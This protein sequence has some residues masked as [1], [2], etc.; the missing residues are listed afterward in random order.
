MSHTHNS[1]TDKNAQAIPWALPPSR[2]SSVKLI[3]CFARIFTQLPS[4]TMHF[5]ADVLG[6][7][8]YWL[9]RKDRRLALKNVRT[10]YPNASASMQRSIVV[11][12]FQHVVRSVFDLMQLTAERATRRPALKIRHLE[13][14]DVA[15][16]KERGVVLITGHYGNPEI[17]ALALRGRCTSPGFLYKPTRFAWAIDQFRLYRETVL[18]RGSGF[19]PLESSARGVRKAS[20]LLKHGSVVVMAADLTWSSGFIPVSFLNRTFR[21]SRVPAS[22]SLRTRAL[23]LPVITVRNHDGGYDIILEEPIEHPAAVSRFDA[24]QTMTETFARILE[25][26]VDSAPEQWCWLQLADQ[27]EQVKIQTRP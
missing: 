5:V 13:R 6:R 15:L 12:S 4:P 9:Y 27:S 14:L 19:Q 8:A 17:L 10:F 25:R 18:L 22:I 7:V 1:D 26:Y 20:R 3:L 21:M 2:T 23:L 24:E 16:G 11:R